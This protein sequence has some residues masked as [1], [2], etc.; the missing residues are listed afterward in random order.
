MGWKLIVIALCKIEEA[1]P[2]RWYHR[3]GSKLLIAWLLID[4]IPSG[5]MTLSFI[6]QQ[7]ALPWGTCSDPK[8]SGIVMAYVTTQPKPKKGDKPKTA[9]DVCD[10]LYTAENLTFSLA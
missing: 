4:L 2:S 10:D 3:R 9:A 8:S 6:L 1:R 7:L 5:L